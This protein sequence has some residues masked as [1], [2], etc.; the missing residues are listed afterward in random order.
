MCHAVTAED[1]GPTS[2]G[3]DDLYESMNDRTAGLCDQQNLSRLRF[4]LFRELRYLNKAFMGDKGSHTSTVRPE[5]YLPLDIERVHQR[6]FL[7]TE[8]TL[9]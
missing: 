3:I 5:C 2:T 6:F 7:F 1:V 9:C 8:R 4:S